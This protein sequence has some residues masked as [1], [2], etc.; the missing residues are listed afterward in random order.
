VPA[1]EPDEPDDG[2]F[3]CFGAFDAFDAFEVEV[4]GFDVGCDGDELTVFVMLALFAASLTC[5]FGSRSAKIATTSTTAPRTTT[6][7]PA[8][9]SRRRRRAC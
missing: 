9:R 1:C 2:L 6:V 7:M 4:A 5:P 3:E 8:A